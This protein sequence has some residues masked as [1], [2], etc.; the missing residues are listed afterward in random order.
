MVGTKF[1]KL[2][3][4]FGICLLAGYFNSLY[5]LPLIPSWFA[6]LKKP[7]LFLPD[8]WFAPAGLVV[9]LLLGLTLYFIWKSDTTEQHEKHVCIVLFVFGLIL[10]C[11]WVYTFFGLRSP[12]FG[13][14]IMVFLFA[15]LMATMYQ[16]VRV[17]FGATLLFLPY[18]LVTF[19]VA[20][21]NYR[22]VIMNPAIPFFPL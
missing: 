5:A 14:M 18:L 21:T 17:S 10:N 11:V 2:V 12:F 6:S 20:Y 9:Y 3:F 1:V 15:I 4:S 16:T 22:I 8:S 7:D 13:L 19:A